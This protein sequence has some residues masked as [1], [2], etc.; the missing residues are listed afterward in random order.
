MRKMQD[1]KMSVHPAY[2]NDTEEGAE[3]LGL[4]GNEDVRTE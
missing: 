4:M 2:G 3:G 1:K